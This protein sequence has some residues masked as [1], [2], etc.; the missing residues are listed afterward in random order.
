MERKIGYKTSTV[1]FLLTASCQKLRQTLA[2]KK[3][4]FYSC[5][6]WTESREIFAL[7]LTKIKSWEIFL[8]Y[9]HGWIPLRG[10][11]KDIFIKSGYFKKNMSMQ[12]IILIYEFDVV[13]HRHQCSIYARCISIRNSLHFELMDQFS[14][15]SR[16]TCIK[17]TVRR[18]IR[19][20]YIQKNVEDKCSNIIARADKKA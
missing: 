18:N 9:F 5:R 12:Q 20:R 11:P 16:R 19:D 7:I 17:D 6:C 13:K 15:G 10:S 4:L 1:V 2:Q 8:I 3:Y 14:F